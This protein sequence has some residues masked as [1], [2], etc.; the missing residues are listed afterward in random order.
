MA[1]SLRF[2]VI[3]LQICPIFR[4]QTPVSPIF[5][6]YSMSNRTCERIINC[7]TLLKI[8]VNTEK[9]RRLIIIGKNT[10]QTKLFAFNESNI[11]RVRLVWQKTAMTIGIIY[12]YVGYVVLFCEHRVQCQV[13]FNVCIMDIACI[14]I[15]KQYPHI[16]GCCST[17]LLILSNE[18][19]M[20]MEI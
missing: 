5:P 6:S 17:Q 11:F 1:R 4:S 15:L 20:E 12:W 18:W 3:I 8:P 13:H 16:C 19:F 14:K 7:F 10:W 2:W 9:E